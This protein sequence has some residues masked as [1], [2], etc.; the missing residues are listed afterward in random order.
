MNTEPEVSN[1]C[2][3]RKIFGVIGEAHGPNCG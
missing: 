1:S 2:A 3:K